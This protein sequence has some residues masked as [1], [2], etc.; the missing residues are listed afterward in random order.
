MLV[1]SLATSND[2]IANL[3]DEL[4]VCSE[5]ESLG[6]NGREETGVTSFVQ[7]AC[8]AVSAPDGSHVVMEKNAEL[9]NLNS[10]FS[11][12]V[13]L[14]RSNI[15]DFRRLLYGREITDLSDFF[16]RFSDRVL[17]AYGMRYTIV[18]TLQVAAT[19][20]HQGVLALT[21]QYGATTLNN[22]VGS[23]DRCTNLPHVR[24]D[25]S[26]E[27]MVQ[28]RVPF[29]Y[30]HEFMPVALPSG[31]PYGTVGVANLTRIPSVEGMSPPTFH[32]FMHL[33]DL[34]FF[35]ASPL[36]LTAVQLQSGLRKEF[37]AESHP[38]SNA[39][40]TVGRTLS[41][42]SKVVPVPSLSAISGSTGWFLEAT[43]GAL[44]AFGWARP[45]VVD[46]MHRMWPV[47][48]VGEFNQDI[49]SA[50]QVVGPMTSNTLRHSIA[51]S[52]TEVDEMSLGFVTSR[53]SQVCL[54]ELPDT[55]ASGSLIYACPISPA[56]MYMQVLPPTRTN[57][58]LKK[59]EST[60]P[61]AALT[62][63][64]S[65]SGPIIANI[66]SFAPTNLFYASQ[67]FKYWRGSMVFRFTFAKTKLHAG[68]VIVTFTPFYDPES[69]LG[70]AT[71]S[72]ITLPIP[73][74]SP[75]VHPFGHT[76]IF[77]LK[78]DNVFEFTVPYVAP[79]PYCSF[80]DYTGSISMHVLEPLVGPT[81]AAHT[82][83]VLVEVRGGDDYEL[84][85]P[86]N[87]IFTPYERVELQS[88][89]KVRNDCEYTM[90]ERLLSLKQ[91]LGIPSLYDEHTIGAGGDVTTLLPHWA[92]TLTAHPDHVYTVGIPSYIARAYAFVKGSTDVHVYVHGSDKNAIS[93]HQQ[94]EVNSPNG[95]AD[96]FL[97]ASQIRVQS[98]VGKALHARLPAY[99]PLV[100]LSTAS[101]TAKWP[102]F[103]GGPTSFYT[104]KV[105]SADE[106]KF[107]AYVCAGDD[108]FACMYIGPPQLYNDPFVF[109]G[110]AVLGANL[111]KESV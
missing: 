5:I 65:T 98:T 59:L 38:F 30:A 72:P 24:L 47:N 107:S 90:G 43:A 79:V 84:A 106:N 4:T 39:V 97:D 1:H 16:P 111:E 50:S 68:R 53:P 82:I 51:F 45:Q 33:E 44:R 105:A 17:G 66:Q 74:Y 75:S 96:P 88:G 70:R 58:F 34:E 23:I 81:N 94:V 28:L 69:T 29:L 31:G 6:V 32:L 89:I 2:N 14:R 83:D 100:R 22:V 55:L 19:P 61:A 26:A 64:D 56:A 48:N 62:A 52:G 49:A 92:S 15:A 12:P 25:L 109:N 99:Q 8:S 87:P 103:H 104:L 95:V 80:S 42:V 10:Y 85:N 86:R 93:I 73:Q 3:R 7:E 9:Q 54:V 20:F 76:A 101:C 37:K 102:S 27:T 13:S 46:P 110:T 67:I 35:G 40:G 63:A 108:A 21:F 71:R 36:S 11:R 57:S 91:L 77:N 60:A 78:D 41:A 18:F